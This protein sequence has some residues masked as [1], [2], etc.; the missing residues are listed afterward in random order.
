MLLNVEKTAAY[1]MKDLLAG[2]KIIQHYLDNGIMEETT[3]HEWDGYIHPSY[4]DW[5]KPPEKQL[6][7]HVNKGYQKPIEAHRRFRLGNLE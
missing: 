7:A 1:Q 6:L 3:D 4:L 2:K 5:S